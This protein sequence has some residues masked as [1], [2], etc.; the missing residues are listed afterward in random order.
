MEFDLFNVQKLENFIWEMTYGFTK[1]LKLWKNI[2]SLA[3]KKKNK[4]TSNQAKIQKLYERLSAENM[5]S[6]K[7]LIKCFKYSNRNVK[8]SGIKQTL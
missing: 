5:I 7:I 4:E 8:S 6:N 1:S 2:T 3:K